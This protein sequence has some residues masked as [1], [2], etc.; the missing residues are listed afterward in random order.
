[1]NALR[2]FL[3]PGDEILTVLRHVSRSGMSRSIDLYIVK[4]GKPSQLSRRVAE[5][6][7]MKLDETNGGIKIG[8]CG[9]DMGFALVYNLGATIFPDGVSRRG[10]RHSDGGYGLRHEWL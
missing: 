5:A 6:L 7:D 3:K 8:G 4:K 10:V 9:M 1:M 2:T